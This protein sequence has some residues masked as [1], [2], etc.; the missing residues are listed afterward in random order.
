MCAWVR[1][2]KDP[3]Y[4]IDSARKSKGRGTHLFQ[5]AHGVAFHW[6][7]GALQEGQTLRVLLR[8]LCRGGVRRRGVCLR[9]VALGSMLSASRRSM[10]QMR[11][12]I[13]ITTGK[14]SCNPLPFL[15][16]PTAAVLETWQKHIEKVGTDCPSLILNQGYRFLINPLT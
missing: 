10:L 3:G 16:S 8:L 12:Q 1:Y 7:Q 15:F 13:L 5:P 9:I 11:C 6:A 4:M 2:V 14:M